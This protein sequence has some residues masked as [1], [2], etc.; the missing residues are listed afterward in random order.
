LRLLDGRLLVRRL[1]LLLLLLLLRL[2]HP[3]WNPLGGLLRNGRQ[4]Q[5]DEN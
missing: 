4:R 2:A 3:G 1:R 5:S